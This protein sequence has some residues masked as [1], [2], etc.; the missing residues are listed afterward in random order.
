MHSPN[1]DHHND[2]GRQVQ[3]RLGAVLHR[4]ATL[5][6]G[7]SGYE[8]RKSTERLNADTLRKISADLERA[9]VEAQEAA[10]SYERLRS[11]ASHALQRADLLFLLSPIPCVILDRNSLIID[12]NPAAARTVNLS[13]RHLVGK[14][15][16]LFVG[17]DRAEFLARLE[18]LDHSA[19]AIRWPITVRPR[20]RGVLKVT[21]AAAVDAEDHIV[22][23][24]LPAAADGEDLP[25][26]DESLKAGHA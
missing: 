22:A 25:E 11:S 4:L 24:L 5:D 13:Q 23:M 15:F 17:S 26:V 2:Y 7:V 10:M 14:P 20:E 21:F 9:F 6:L 8:Q 16:Q 18:S 1:L 19:W 12:A 3:D